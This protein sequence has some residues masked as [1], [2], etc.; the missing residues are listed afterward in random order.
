MFTAAGS[1]WAYLTKIICFSGHN[2]KDKRTLIPIVCRGNKHISY[3]MLKS[4]Q[5]D[6][7]QTSLEPI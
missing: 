3:L 6:A 7:A 5:R 1:A 4:K 2:A